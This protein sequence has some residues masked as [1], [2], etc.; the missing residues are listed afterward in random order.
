MT[1]YGLTPTGFVA[2]TQQDVRD[3][4]RDRLRSGLGSPSLP[5]SSE[6][7]LGQLVAILGERIGELWDLAQLIDSAF[8]P[9]AAL[10]AQLESLCALTG[11]YRQAARKSSTTAILTGVPG[12][13]IPE[14]SRV[15]TTTLIYGLRVAAPGDE[16]ATMADVTLAA[17]AAWSAAATV[18]VG[19]LVN[20][21]TGVFRCMSGGTTGGSAPAWTTGMMGDGT[22]VVDNTASWA[23]MGIGTAAAEVE[24][25]AVEAGAIEA[26]A[27][28]LTEIRTP[29][30]GWQGVNSYEDAVIGAGEQSDADLRVAR[31]FEVAAGGAAG[32]EQIRGN[33]LQ[34]TGVTSCRVFY[35][36][37]QATDGDGLPPH[38]IEVLVQGGSDEEI[39]EALWSAVSIGT[40]YVG[41]ESVDVADSEGV[42]HTI[43]FSRPTEVPIY[44]GVTLVKDPS[45]YPADGDDQ[46][47]AAIADYGNALAV[48]RDAVSSSLAARVFGV[49]GVLD[50]TALNISTAPAPTMPTTITITS[51][52]LATYDVANISLSTSNGTP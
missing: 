47:K 5:L 18:A 44:V 49:A 3:A 25:E 50:V 14:S 38:S 11:T 27:Y 19:D 15:R 7:L 35:N 23:Y 46:V 21:G 9:D 24:V 37:T 22:L 41:S 6:D 12:T 13:S 51:R 20:N 29:V 52:Q 8:D 10:G 33:V 39:A 30:A 40:T 43:L 2:K 42:S 48:G 36:N 32:Y 28:D 45:T 26:G 1:T 34:V 16:F 31:A 4:I 17:T